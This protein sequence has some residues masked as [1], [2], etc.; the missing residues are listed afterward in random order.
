MN[1]CIYC[2]LEVSVCV[3]QVPGV[4]GISILCTLGRFLLLLG[5]LWQQLR[6]HGDII[7]ARHSVAN[8]K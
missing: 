6:K 5:T 7:A 2:E 4:A 3:Y 1:V 8:I